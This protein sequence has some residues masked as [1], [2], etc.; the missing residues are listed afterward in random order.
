MEREGARSEWAA[1]KAARMLRAA[2]SGTQQR[3]E[4]EQ[5]GVGTREGRGGAE[6]AMQRRSDGGLR[7]PLLRCSLIFYVSI[8]PCRAT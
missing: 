2:T 3:G 1:E 5:Q 4:R 8:W 6:G 7:R